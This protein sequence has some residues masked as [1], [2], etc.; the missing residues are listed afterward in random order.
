MPVMSTMPGVMPT[1]LPDNDKEARRAELQA[2]IQNKLA[3]VGIGAT[4]TAQSGYLWLK[5]L[6]SHLFVISLF[7]I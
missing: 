5:N 4:G 1:L 3:T 2:R 6:F 7:T